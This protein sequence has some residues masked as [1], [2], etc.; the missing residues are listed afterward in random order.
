MTDNTQHFR[1]NL[2]SMI[3]ITFFNLFLILLITIFFV[4]QFCFLTFSLMSAATTTSTVTS[5]GIA[6]KM[7]S[8]F[9]AA[10]KEQPPS[11]FATSVMRGRHSLSFGPSSTFMS[12]W[13]LMINHTK[14]GTN[15]EKRRPYS[16]PFFPSFHQANSAI[17]SFT[18]WYVFKRK[19]AA[20]PWV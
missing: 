9:R 16:L 14:G 5:M 20:E 18:V 8:Y 2:G 7:R 17:V 1:V 6:A 10:V 11:L 19:V 12:C 4:Q 15:K 3:L 13:F